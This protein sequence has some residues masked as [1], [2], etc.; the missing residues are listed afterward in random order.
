MDN[1]CPS[2]KCGPF[3]NNTDIT[4][5]TVP[6]L[7]NPVY[8][9]KI[10]PGSTPNYTILNLKC[11]NECCSNEYCFRA[12]NKNGDDLTTPSEEVLLIF[13]GKVL[14]SFTKNPSCYWSFPIQLC[15]ETPSNDLWFFFINRQ[16]WSLIEPGPNPLNSSA[17]PPKRYGHQSVLVE[18]A[19]LENDT[20]T[21]VL[22][23]YLYVY[24]GICVDIGGACDDLWA[25]EI[26]WASQ[27]YYPQPS[28]GFWNRGNH[29]TKISGG[30]GPGARGFHSM[31]V[32][33]NFLYIYLFGGVY[34]NGSDF[35]Y[36]NDLW[37]FSIANNT[38]Q[39]LSLCVISAIQRS[40]KFWDGISNSTSVSI[41]DIYT[42]DSISYS[43][44][45]QNSF[46]N[47][48]SGTVN[49]PSCRGFSSLTI[50]KNGDLYIFGGVQDKANNLTYLH[51]IWIIKS[52]GADCAFETTPN[53]FIKD[54]NDLTY[55]TLTYPQGL[56]A[57]S[58][59]YFQ[60]FNYLFEYGGFNENGT[61]NKLWLW[62]RD[63]R[64][65]HDHSDNFQY[66]YDV[67][68][69]TT[70]QIQDLKGHILVKTANG[71]IIHG[72]VSYNPVPADN[73]TAFTLNF[74]TNFP[75]N[76]QT[77][78]NNYQV[79]RQNIQTINQ[80]IYRELAFQK[81]LGNPCFK[82]SPSLAQFP[83]ANYPDYSNN[84]YFYN[85]CNET[86]DSSQGQCYFGQYYCTDG[87]YGDKCENPMCPNSICFKDT[88]IFATPL[89][90][91]CSKH[92]QCVNGV[93]N[94][95]Q[96]YTGENCSIVDCQNNCSGDAGNCITQFVQN[97][98]R[99]RID[100]K[101]GYDD[102][103]ILFCL[104]D[105]GNNGKC[106]AGEC[107][108]Y[109]SSNGNGGFNGTDCSVYNISLLDFGERINVIWFLAVLL[110]LL[111]Y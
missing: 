101:R 93:C 17:L 73:L 60:D 95:D 13:G 1:T 34:Q 69:N 92:G 6:S 109:G 100:Q 96:G 84:L 110:L 91:F 75:M 107:F 2:S 35:S 87:W 62:L 19:V 99:C 58:G 26:P 24:G 11:P 14:N 49:I 42:T 23:K 56:G 97:Q 10:N 105:C 78:F 82:E 72:G 111:I 3:C 90:E 65:W 108:C 12:L 88:S 16:K 46:Q 4:T 43:T 104:N 18:R 30:M 53:I 48:Y 51:D 59:V 55:E 81:S 74:V 40:V 47:C 80:T 94:C 39:K 21:T 67:N 68:L 27:R 76:C 20:N 37:Q 83:D 98:C 106:I 71:L 7:T 28:S 52:R 85:S 5:C 31:T 66:F 33:A 89:C 29:W 54:I 79:N 45:S 102:C 44:V 63:S 38:W 50:D 36:S 22:R 15:D 25:Y 8:S 64:L 32:D 41:N 103:S 57:M 9:S 86:I 70:Y 61:T 77:L